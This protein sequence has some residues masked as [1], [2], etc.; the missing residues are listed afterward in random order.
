MM[1]H[2]AHHVDS[3]Q[4]AEPLHKNQGLDFQVVDYDSIAATYDRRF[5][6]GQPEGI[7]E[8]LVGL[9]G[10]LKAKRVLEV[11]CGT[12]HWLAQLSLLVPRLFG[13]DLS[14][15]MLHKAR[16]SGSR[17]LVRGEARRLPFPDR[18]LDMVYCVNAI[19][20]FFDAQAFVSQAGRTLKSGGALAVI[21][22]QPHRKHSWY[23]YQY[24]ESVYRRDVKRFP[25]WQQIQAWMQSS[26]FRRIELRPV[27]HIFEIK[28]GRQVLKDPF[29][30][31]NSC[32]QLALL[33]DQAYTQ[34]IARIRADIEQ[35]E[36]RG[37]SLEFISDLQIFML[38]GYQP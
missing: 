15:G 37:E 36:A 7:A 22:S 38:V 30:E 2:Q 12:G 14:A 6:T 1:E 20:H 28:H 13:L 8:T 17:N 27:E 11:G 5:N 35:A 34:G 19:H 23:V 32:S 33:S 29:L 10:A 4:P 16:Q 25:S 21:G 24:F 3:S 31:K 26:G 18:C 9:V